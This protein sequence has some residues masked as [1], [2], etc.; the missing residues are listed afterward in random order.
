M[1]AHGTVILKNIE[2]SVLRGVAVRVWTDPSVVLNGGVQR[3]GAIGNV[4]SEPAR[5]ENYRMFDRKSGL[6]RGTPIRYS[7]KA[8]FSRP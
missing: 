2:N 4:V 1:V 6:M 7:R 3:L 5:V 8:A